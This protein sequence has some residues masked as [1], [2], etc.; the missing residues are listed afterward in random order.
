LFLSPCFREHGI[1]ELL[2][3]EMT[4]PYHQYCPLNHVSKHHI[5]TFV[6]HIQ[7]QWLYHFPLSTSSEKKFFLI[8]NLNFHW[9]NS[10]PLAV[11]CEC[12]IET[13]LSKCT[14]HNIS[15]PLGRKKQR[16]KWKSEK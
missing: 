4:S 6:E 2:R 3:L 5:Y 9:H 16:L 10:R 11:A 8:S 14:D 12:S 15:A 13:G 1:T 7:G